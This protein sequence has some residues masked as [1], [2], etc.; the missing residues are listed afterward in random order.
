M[1]TT[2]TKRLFLFKSNSPDSSRPEKFVNVKIGVNSSSLEKDLFCDYTLIKSGD[3]DIFMTLSL[4][5]AIYQS[6]KEN[7]HEG[8][9][10]VF[11]KLLHYLCRHCH[12]LFTGCA[13]LKNHTKRQH[14]GP[15]LCSPCNFLKPD[16]MS[17]KEHQ[18]YCFFKC[19]VDGCNMS[20]KSLLEAINHK[21]RFLKSS[22]VKD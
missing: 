20:H 9:G 21:R 12:S 7:G 10:I 5:G 3:K 13:K 11:E 1:L 2:G 16:I 15:I 8:P 17:L 14:V 19:N 18:K 6:R 22:G 4:N